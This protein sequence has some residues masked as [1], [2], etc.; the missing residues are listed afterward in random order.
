MLYISEFI[1]LFFFCSVIWLWYD[2]ISK[3]ELAIYEGKRIAN[4]LNLQ[5]LDQTVHCTKISLVRTSSNWP[6]IK[7]IYLFNVSSNNDDRINCQLTIVG[8]KLIE[9]YVPPYPSNL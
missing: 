8:A 1:I 2:I 5:F 9:W 4:N 7:R 6:A 3:R